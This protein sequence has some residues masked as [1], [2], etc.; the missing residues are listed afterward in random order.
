MTDPL[1][2]AMRFAGAALRAQSVRIRVAT[3]N[4]SNAQSSGA[5]PGE[6]PYQRK[7]VTFADAL[8]RADGGRFVSVRSIGTDSAPF[9][10]VRDPGHPAADE[11]GD[12]KMPNVEPLIEIADLKEAGRSYAANLQIIRESREL[13]AMTVDLLKT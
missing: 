11:K 2:S 4:L 8:S 5:A 12:V 13:L 3:E 6:S 9:R 1:Q 7:T 10:I